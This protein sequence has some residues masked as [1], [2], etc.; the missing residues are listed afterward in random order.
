MVSKTNVDA[1]C[2][3]VRV[4]ALE[5][6]DIADDSESEERRDWS[7]NGDTAKQVPFLYEAKY[8]YRKMCTSI[9]NIVDE[10]WWDVDNNIHCIWN[11]LHR[12]VANGITAYMILRRLFF[13]NDANGIKEIE[14]EKR[15]KNKTKAM[16]STKFRKMHWWSEI[17]DFVYLIL[18]SHCNFIIRSS[19]VN[20][21]SF[22]LDETFMRVFSAI[23]KICWG[24][25]D[26]FRNTIC[27]E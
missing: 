8:A 4:L 9:H 25:D 1:S 2:T 10:Y 6:P 3:N 24:N 16:N 12:I 22:H 13:L 15:N 23:R 17:T 18:S 14:N 11:A 20:M 5:N 27:Y 21:P 19:Q 7:N 26:S